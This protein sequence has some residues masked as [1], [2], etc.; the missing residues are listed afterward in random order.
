MFERFVFLIC[1]FE[2]NVYRVFHWMF[3]IFQRN[4]KVHCAKPWHNIRHKNRSVSSK[5]LWVS[6]ELKIEEKEK[7]AVCSIFSVSLQP[8][9]WQRWWAKEHKK[10]EQRINY[11]ATSII[12]ILNSLPLGFCL[13][14]ILIYYCFVLIYTRA[15]WALSLSHTLSFV[16]FCWLFRYVWVFLVFI[17]IVRSWRFSPPSSFKS[18]WWWNDS[19]LVI[20]TMFRCLVDRIFNVSIAHKSRKRERELKIEHCTKQCQTVFG[21]PN[22]RKDS[23]FKYTNTIAFFVTWKQCNRVSFSE[24]IK[25]LL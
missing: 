6:N 11:I 13:C 17:I 15:R 5:K 14:I 21:P 12:F 20:V 16:V 24:R 1:S 8:F 25:R 3:N 23:H 19:V 22:T 2:L 7:V 10:N 9:H 4:R 18:C